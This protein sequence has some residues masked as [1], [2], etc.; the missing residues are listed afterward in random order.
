MKGDEPMAEAI[1]TFKLT[2]PDDIKFTDLDISSIPESL[3]IVINMTVIEHILEANHI[4]MEEVMDED[5]F[6]SSLL[7]SWYEHWLSSGGEHNAVM[8]QVRTEMNA[9]ADYGHD[10]VITGAP[11]Q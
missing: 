8:E 3:E 10:V 11:L 5:D 7:L 2:I 4:S 9:V 1:Q 6:L